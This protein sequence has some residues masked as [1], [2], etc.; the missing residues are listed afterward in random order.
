[1]WNQWFS[2][3]FRGYRKGKLAWNGLI[4][5]VLSKKANKEKLPKCTYSGS[6]ILEGF[7]ASI[8]L[9]K[10]NKRNIR[11]RCDICSK[12][13]IK[14]SE[15]FQWDAFIVNFED[16]SHLVLVCPLLTLSYWVI[17]G[18]CCRR[19]SELSWTFLWVLENVWKWKS[20]KSRQR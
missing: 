17:L 20:S 4:R 10:V 14:T 11:T 1:M 13:T 5:I 16:I 3:V 7:P 6:S 9:L 2:D 19:L 15:Q 8:Y 18:Y 12:L